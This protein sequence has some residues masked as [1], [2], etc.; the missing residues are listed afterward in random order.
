MGSVDKGGG[1]VGQ[2]AGGVGGL[3][4]HK[5]QL[6]GVGGDVLQLRHVAGGGVHLQHAS[7]LQNL[8]A[9]ALVGGVAGDSDLVSLLQL[10]HVGDLVGVQGQ[11][12]HDG[13]AQDGDVIAQVVDLLLEVGLVLE[14]VQ[15][16][17]PG[18]QGVVGQLVFGKLHQLHLDVVLGQQLVDRVPLLVVGP[19]HAHLD[20]SGLSRRGGRAGAG[21]GAGHGAGA[22]AVSAVVSAA[23]GQR[24]GQGRGQ[25]E[26]KN[27]LLFHFKFLL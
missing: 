4:L 18:V 22:A 9:P 13:V 12:G 14:G 1:H 2:E 10:A 25:R 11:G 19:H 15:V 5:L 17:L 26:G 23:G 16:D 7:G 3:H 24:Q 27:V 21:V 20:Y 8:K 6:Q